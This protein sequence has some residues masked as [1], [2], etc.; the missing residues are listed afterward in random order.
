MLNFFIIFYEKDLSFQDLLGHHLSSRPTLE[1]YAR[2]L[3]LGTTFGDYACGLFT[4]GDLLQV[5][6]LVNFLKRS[7]SEITFERK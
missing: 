1:I 4:Q 2:E 5:K 7:S 6:N 3:H